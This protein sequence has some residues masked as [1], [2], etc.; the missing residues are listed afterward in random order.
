VQDADGQRRGYVTSPWWSP[1]L[2]SNIALAYV[3]WDCTDLG[4][5]L[6]VELPETYSLRSGEPVEAE[7]SEV[8]FRPSEHP[9]ARERAKEEGLDA[10]D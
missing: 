4:T 2:A 6:F 10:V 1:E 3:P 8:P 9:G 7:V 5:Q